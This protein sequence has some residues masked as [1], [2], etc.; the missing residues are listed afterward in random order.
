MSF[1]I[2]RRLRNVSSKCQLI[3]SPSRSGSVA[4]IRALSSFRAS[5]IALTC[6]LLSFPTSQVIAKLSS[7]LTE[8]SLGGRSRTCPY[9]ARTVYSDP[10]YLLIVFALAGDS[11]TTTGIKYP[12]DSHMVPW[13]RNM[14]VFKGLCQCTFN[15]LCE[16]CAHSRSG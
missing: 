1:L 5:A 14:V 3:A 15:D 6:F 11:T 13:R 2:A 16:L 4:R 8:P 10:K 7:G 9:E 12:F